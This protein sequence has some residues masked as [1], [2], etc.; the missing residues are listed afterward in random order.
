MSPC[1]RFAINVVA[2]RALV[3]RIPHQVPIL[4]GLAE[5][6]GDRAQLRNGAF[7]SGDIGSATLK[8]SEL[9][10]QSPK[11]VPGWLL[12]IDTVFQF[13]NLDLHFERPCLQIQS[14]TKLN[15]DWFTSGPKLVTQ[16]LIAVATVAYQH[17]SKRTEVALVEQPDF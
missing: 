15:T 2:R 5:G 14:L 13:Y 3:E 11:A 10:G 6:G 1:T 12:A 7:I 9:R 8:D 16:W 4:P 17:Y